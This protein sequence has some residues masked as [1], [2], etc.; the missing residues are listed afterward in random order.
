MKKI[1][2]RTIQVLLLA[3]FVFLIINGKV[4][5]W[6][7]LL[8]F[9]ILASIFL[10]RFYCGWMCPIN[11]VFKG[12]TWF[13]KKLNINSFKTPKF[14][15]NKWIRIIAF[16]IFAVLF[17][18]IM[19]TK[20]KLPVLPALFIIGVLTTLFFP[21]ELWHRY[22]CPYG[23][24]LRVSSSRTKHTMYIDEE[25]CTNCGLCTTVCPGAAIVQENGDHKI[26]KGDCL[27]CME[28]E[29]VC[30]KDSISYI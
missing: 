23:S 16:G 9:G 19:I 10:G 26:L 3:L 29:A 25:T 13:K 6:V 24:M 8:V 15:K 22:L 1:L 27:V 14:L 4:Q 17:G 20:A 5:V 18:F 28:C 11:T 12:I 21:E 2:Q 7:G 30:P